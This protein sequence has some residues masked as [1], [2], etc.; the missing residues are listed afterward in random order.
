MQAGHEAI[1]NGFGDEVE[2][3]DAGEDG[4]IEEALLHEELFAHG[5][6]ELRL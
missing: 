5:P 1:D 2:S 3:G 4:R 6:E